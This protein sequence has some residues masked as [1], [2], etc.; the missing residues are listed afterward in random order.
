MVRHVL[1]VC[2]R[3]RV[4]SVFAQ[5]YL[6][7]LVRE[8]NEA[9][10]EN[11]K[12]S[13]AGFYP[14]KLSDILDEAHI[15]KQDPFFDRDMSHVV[16]EF[17]HHKGI[18]SPDGWR[19]RPLTPEL[20]AEADL[21]IVAIAAQKEEILKQYPD[22]SKKLFTFREMAAF[23]ESIL[24]EAFSGLP[25]DDTFWAYCEDYSPYVSKVIEEVEELLNL[26]YHNILKQLG[27]Q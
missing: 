8:K 24:F 19:S 12:I 14:K 21:I 4:R 23:E 2:V 13:S 15:P 27:V 3:N 1:F 9:L 5:Y 22:V 16:R 25:M 18:A 17:L 6:E 20:V 11:I 10:A 26:G 7:K